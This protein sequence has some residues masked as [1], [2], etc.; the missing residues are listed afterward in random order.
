M[1]LTIL[2]IVVSQ[3]V[4]TAISSSGPDSK[5]SD[6]DSN[7]AAQ[8]E[9][10]YIPPAQRQSILNTD[11]NAD[12][13]IV[14]VGQRPKKRKRKGATSELVDSPATAVEPKKRVK[15]ENEGEALEPFDFDAAPNI[16]DEPGPM[17]PPAK[18][19]REKGRRINGM[20]ATSIHV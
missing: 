1:A 13:S 10:P 11:P 5:V 4:G 16:L 18:K 6:Q 9:I 17:A 3:R 8:A 2:L 15:S 14:V 20:H 12:D 7:A 19:R